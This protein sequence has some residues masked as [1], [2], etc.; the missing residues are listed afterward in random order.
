MLA[1]KKRKIPAGQKKYNL[2][3]SPGIQKKK[4]RF[5]DIN[6]SGT[7][8]LDKKKKDIPAIIFYWAK[9]FIMKI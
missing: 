6:Y 7:G 1:E 4:N 2:Q 5:F 3:F 9:I 8:A